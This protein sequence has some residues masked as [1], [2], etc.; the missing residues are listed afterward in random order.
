M[1]LTLSSL[2]WE[3]DIGVSSREKGGNSEDATLC[4]RLSG[5]CHCSY[6]RGR[7]V[8]VVF[9]KGFLESLIAFLKKCW[10]VLNV[11]PVY[12]RGEKEISPPHGWATVSRFLKAKQ[13][14]QLFNW[15]RFISIEVRC[16]AVWTG[17][18]C[19][20]QDLFFCKTRMHPCSFLNSHTLWRRCRNYAAN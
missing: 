16:H 1:L 7:N 12:S 6:L 10:S 14:K 3:M 8:V 20:F 15:G 19:S 11:H 13:N 5:S 2:L 9:L 18:I 4:Q 17:Q